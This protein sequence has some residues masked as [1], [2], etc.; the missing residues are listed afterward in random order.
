MHLDFIAIKSGA[1]IRHKLQEIQNNT[2]ACLPKYGS[3]LYRDHKTIR[4]LSLST[5][6]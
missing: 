1:Q 4:P 5:K 3:L 2:V 6:D